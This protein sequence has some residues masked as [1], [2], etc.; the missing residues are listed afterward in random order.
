MRIC[1][2]CIARQQ[3][4]VR[5]QRLECAQPTCCASRRVVVLVSGCVGGRKRQYALATAA[6]HCSREEGHLP[7]PRGN[8]CVLR[9]D[10]V[11]AH[12]LL[13]V[14][15]TNQL[16]FMF[17]VNNYPPVPPHHTTSEI[18]QQITCIT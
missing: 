6:D 1:D 10:R 5:T 4:T 3:H 18:V 14:P 11:A 12:R 17:H 7:P 15:L 16:L 2:S 9:C 8:K 13:G